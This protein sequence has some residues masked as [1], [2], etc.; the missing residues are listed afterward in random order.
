MTWADGE[1][2]S[3]CLDDDHD[4]AEV[5]RVRYIPQNYLEVVCNEIKV[6]SGEGF[7]SE[8]KSVI[9]SHVPLAERLGKPTLDELLAQKTRQTNQTIDILK[10]ELHALNERIVDAETRLT[11]E[12]R[13]ALQNRLDLKQQELTAHDATRPPETLPPSDDPE[14]QAA[15]ARATADIDQAR[16]DLGGVEAELQKAQA[17]Q[18]ALAKATAALTDAEGQLANFERLHA[19]LLTNLATDLTT[20]DIQAESLIRLTIDRSPLDA[21]RAALTAAT[22]TAKLRLYSI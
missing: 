7:D 18:R 2:V 21:K 12:H 5:E 10:T 16:A 8:L 20:L 6:K 1:V 19:T 4:P 3:C 17:E 15:V 11:P 22:A 9:F 14:K 13:H